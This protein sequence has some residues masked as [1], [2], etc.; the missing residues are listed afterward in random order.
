MARGATARLFVA[1]DPPPDV[2]EA[3]VEWARHTAAEWSAWSPRRSWRAPRVLKDEALHLTLCFLGSRPLG[4]IPDLASALGSCA[5]H[6]G[7]LALGAPLWLPPRRPRAL[8]VEV[9]DHPGEL[10]ALQASLTRTLSQASGWEPERRR[11]RPHITLVRVG[12]APRR[13]PEGER[14]LLGATPQLR[15][16]PESVVLYRSSPTPAGSVYEPLATSEIGPLGD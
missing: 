8:A 7:E 9:R 14:P 2:R 13:G 16:T 15:F 10:A 12:A 3:L 5:E 6:V 4:E 1:V 11:F